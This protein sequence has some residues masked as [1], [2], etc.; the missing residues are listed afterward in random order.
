[1]K[2]Q[3]GP[4]S[5]TFQIF[6]EIPALLIGMAREPLVDLASIRWRCRIMH[7]RHVQV[8]DQHVAGVC[9]VW[10]TPGIYPF[11]GQHG[12]REA[13]R[14]QEILLVARQ[15]AVRSE[16]VQDRETWHD[17]AVLSLPP[18]YLPKRQYGA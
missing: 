13:G 8:R 5:A 2:Q 4:Q 11:A 17:W 14:L 9:F 10:R 3:M 6:D 15:Q 18:T 16:K 1:M 7:C 12:L